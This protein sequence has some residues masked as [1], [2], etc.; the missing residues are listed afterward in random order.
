[1]LR[2]A[3]RVDAN[4]PAQIDYFSFTKTNVEIGISA[5]PG[6]VKVLFKEY[7]C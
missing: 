4:Q 6:G 5:P 7:P 3:S 1:M 2:T